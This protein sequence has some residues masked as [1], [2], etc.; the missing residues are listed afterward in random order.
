MGAFVHVHVFPGVDVHV[1]CVFVCACVYVSVCVLASV[2][3]YVNL[4]SLY[5]VGLKPSFQ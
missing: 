4:W 2:R 3:V 1:F 5:C